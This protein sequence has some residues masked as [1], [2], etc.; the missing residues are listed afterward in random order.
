M[1]FIVLDFETT[2]LSAKAN[3]IIEIGYA[4]VINNEIT[5][6]HSQL[7]DPGVRIT[8]PKITEITGI[9]NSMIEGA[10]PLNDEMKKLHDLI[11]GKL[12]VAHNAPFDMGFLNNTFYRMD[13]ATYHS[14]L[15]TAN[16]FRNYKKELN[17]NLERA[18]LAVMTQYFGVVNE[19]AHRAGADAEATAKSLIKMCEDIDFKNYMEGA[20]K[21]AKTVNQLDKPTKTDTYMHLF[22][23]HTPIET[24]CEEMKVKISTVSKYFLNWLTYADADPYKDFIKEHLPSENL[25][26]QILKQKAQGISTSNIHRQL[27]G[28]V[29][30]FVIQLVGRLG[31]KGIEVLK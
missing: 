9:D 31:A 27:G 5:E 6:V 23:A 11:K 8:N 24:I 7:V 2:G 13:L 18:S 1:D 12:I 30:Y 20:T 3:R 15:C 10:P 26:N 14:Y 17:I 28:E 4:L 16:M 21:R 29:E 19:A 25:I 22:D